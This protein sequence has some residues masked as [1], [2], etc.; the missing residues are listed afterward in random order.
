MCDRII[1]HRIF[2]KQPLYRWA[3]TILRHD[4]V[5]IMPP[6]PLDCR[7][8]FR[9][10]SFEQLEEHIC[11]MDQRTSNFITFVVAPRIDEG[12]GKHRAIKPKWGRGIDDLAKVRPKYR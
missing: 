9:F 10:W 1:Q 11:T 2:A 3:E 12:A 8:D 5:T 4:A 6:V 7:F